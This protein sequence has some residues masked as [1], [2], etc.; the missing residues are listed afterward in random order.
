MVLMP[1]RVKYRKSQRGKSRGIAIRGSDLTFGEFGLK[2]LENG[3]IKNTQIEAARVAVA[4]KLR[5]AGKFWIR[6][7]PHKPITKKPAET[8]QGKGKGD[9]AGWVAVTRRGAIVFE[10]GG[11]PEA[12]ARQVFRLIAFKLP[13]RTRFVTRGGLG[14]H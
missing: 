2:A 8:R 13:I 14:G 10:L 7:F 3:L 6:V 12:F 11:I 4:R 9:L 1:R 5:G